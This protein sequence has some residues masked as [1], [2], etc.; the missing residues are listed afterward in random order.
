MLPL[1]GDGYAMNTSDVSGSG[2]LN[3]C[4]STA[5]STINSQ[6]ANPSMNS[7]S[8]SNH[9][10]LSQPILPAMQHAPQLRP[11]M[12][13]GS[14]S[15]NFQSTHSTREQ[16]LQS[17]HQ[18]QNF[19]HQPFQQSDQPSVQPVQNQR[20]QYN[21]QHQQLISNADNIRHYSTPSNFSGQLIPGDAIE[22]SS[23]SLLPHVNEQFHVSEFQNQYQKNSSSGNL[24]KGAQLLGQLQGPQ[25]VQALSSQVS[26][27][28]W[29]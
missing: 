1:A 7:K 17:Q 25:N 5:A 26:Q 2:N 12:L 21:Q 23:Q 20:Y 29:L 13:D 10:I 19:Q 8:R 9:G 11:Q 6:N 14:Q 28:I 22:S 18:M 27:K 15:M 16:L 4:G 3:G 24:S